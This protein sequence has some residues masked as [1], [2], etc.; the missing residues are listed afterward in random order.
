MNACFCMQNKIN[1]IN[2]KYLQPFFFVAIY[3]KIACDY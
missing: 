2:K 1:N 3:Y